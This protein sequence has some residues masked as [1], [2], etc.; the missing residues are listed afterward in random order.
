MRGVW[1]LPAGS[2]GRAARDEAGPAR[3][4]PSGRG[5]DLGPSLK[6]GQGAGALRIKQE[7]DLVETRVFS[8]ILP[9]RWTVA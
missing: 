3:A 1:C 5:E 8:I 7:P 2:V 4:R 9:T 6:M